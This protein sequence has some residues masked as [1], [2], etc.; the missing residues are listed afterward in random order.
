MLGKFNKW[1]QKEQIKIENWGYKIE[2]SQ[3]PANT[4][5][6][7][8]YKM[9]LESEDYIAR[10]TFFDSGKCQLEIINVTSEETILFEYLQLNQ[11]EN[12][13]KAFKNFLNTLQK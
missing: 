13:S 6:P 12:L 1:I 8:G 2:I 4:D 7:E 5:N 11:N 3:F 9:D 10:I